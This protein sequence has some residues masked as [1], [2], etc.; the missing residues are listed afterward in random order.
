MVSD[1]EC[2]TNLGINRL[3]I[4]NAY[5]LYR[6]KTLKLGLTLFAINIRSDIKFF[7]LYQMKK[8]HIDIGP[9]VPKRRSMPPDIEGLYSISGMIS[10]I[11]SEY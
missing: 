11:I 5:I 7:I 8:N 1:I 6:I 4:L 10:K 9:D 3:S 2:L